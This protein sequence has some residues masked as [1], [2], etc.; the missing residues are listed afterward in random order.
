MENII[1][2]S[3]VSPISPEYE[4]YL[5]IRELWIKFKEP[6]IDSQEWKEFVDNVRVWVYELFPKYGTIVDKD[7]ED[8]I[9]LKAVGYLLEMREAILKQKTFSAKLK[10]V[11]KYH[12]IWDSMNGF[13]K[14][15]VILKVLKVP[16]AHRSTHFIADKQTL[17]VSDGSK[18][19]I[20]I[21][22]EEWDKKIELEFADYID[23]VLI[24]RYEGGKER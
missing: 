16:I 19:L 17:F 2:R 18:L 5:Q 21:P 24:E 11:V 20:F 9:Y 14:E 4:N 13:N 22:F 7:M 15:I 1:N 8:K 10:E 12:K 6:D 3:T 23:W